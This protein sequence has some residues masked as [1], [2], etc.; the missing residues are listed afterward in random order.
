MAAKVSLSEFEMQ[1]ITNK[2]WILTKNEI[3]GKVYALFGNIAA[4]YSNEELLRELPLEVIALPPKI[5]KGENYKGLPY[6]MLDYPR[7]FGRDDVFAI[8]TFFWWGSFFTITLH[9]KGTYKNAYCNKFMHAI[10]E[11]L[12]AG[13]YINN[14]NGEWEHD[15]HAGTMLPV[16]NTHLPPVNEYEI[17]KLTLK[18]NLS[19]WER[20]EDFYSENFQLLLRV[21]TA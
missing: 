20:A 2:H 5:S 18:L 1:L 10:S 4:R 8:R 13:A 16:S 7:C 14:S 21:V 12:F 15:I 6:V 17:F 3:I 9:L 11:G 19:E